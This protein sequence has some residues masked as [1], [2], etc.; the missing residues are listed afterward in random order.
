MLDDLYCNGNEELLSECRHD[1]WG[2]HN[3]GHSEDA[4]V[5]CS[6][7]VNF[8]QFGI[9]SQVQCL[10]HMHKTQFFFGC[11]CNHLMSV[12]YRK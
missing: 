9:R 6:K 4:G 1:G 10:Q 7:F 12:V 2:N 11:L 5:E 3:C 8:K